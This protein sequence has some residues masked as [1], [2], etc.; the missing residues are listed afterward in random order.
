MKN[1]Q[2]NLARVGMPR[3][4]HLIYLKGDP[5]ASLDIVREPVKKRFLFKDGVPASA[6]SNILNEV[7]GRLL[8]QEGIITQKD[9]EL[10]LQVVL[11]EKKRH[12]QVL[13]S[14][15][16]ITP[17]Q[18]DSFLTLQIK[19]RIFKIFGWNEGTYR[20]V[21][22]DAAPADFPPL[23]LHPAELILE[24]ISLGFYPAPRIRADL[25]EH[26]D[27]P[28]SVAKSFGKYALEDFN[29]NLQEKRFLDSIDGKKTLREALDAS[30][31]LRH[32]ALSLALAFLI[33]GVITSPAEVEEDEFFEEETRAPEAAEATL[34]KKLNAELLFMKSKNALE[35]GEY[36]EAVKTLTG[37]TDLNPMEGEYWAYLGWAVYL[38]DPKN[39]KKAEGILKDAID[40]NNDLDIA[41]HFLGEL[42]QAAGDVEAARKC[43]HTAVEKNPWMLQSVAELKR[44]DICAAVEPGPDA[45][46][47]KAYVEAFGFTDDPFSRAPD[48]KYAYLSGSR[49]EAMESLLRA[50]KKRSGPVL[51][52]GAAGTGKTTLVLELLRRLSSEKILPAVVL[53]P[54]ERELVLIKEINSEVGVTTESDS[55]KEQLLAL[56]MRVSQNKIQGGHT[57][58]VIDQA[59]HLTPGCLKLVQYLTRLKSLQIVLSAEPSLEERLKEADFTELDHKVAAR[60]P[61]YSLSMDETKDYFLKRL[62]AGY[63]LK[64]PACSISDE[65]LVLLFEESGGFP[66]EVNSKAARLLAESTSYGTCDIDNVIALAAFGRKN[67]FEDEAAA[68]V[69]VEKAF[70]EKERAE[71][72][73]SVEPVAPPSEKP[74]PATPA[75][76]GAPPSPGPVKGSEGPKR[77]RPSIEP[78]P[79]AKPRRVPVPAEEEEEAAAEHRTSRLLIVVLLIVIAGLVAACLTGLFRFGGGVVET[80]K[81][82][83]PPPKA[84]DE[85][86]TP[87]TGAPPPPP[88]TLNA[89]GPLDTSAGVEGTAAAPPSEGATAPASAT[90]TG[91]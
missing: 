38:E 7:L 13:I 82:V 61:I 81:A 83:V 19:R 25:K 74:K 39:R 24:G 70:E 66:S 85:V 69:F 64:E 56:G 80:G 8:M 36:A 17:E 23:P 50:V 90:E 73:A 26:M 59:H 33:T 32:R 16:L 40:L 22:S 49:Q 71:P 11:N 20:Y 6:S 87:G 12:G 3:L 88:S 54:P 76:F 55:I 51:L 53:R 46:E 41:W 37:I 62:K 48:P 77:P 31:L 18:L 27:L 78:H 4:L 10:S 65:A 5:A 34:D 79:H 42:Y 57:L 68:E 89:S 43:F 91:P 30:D 28:V 21:K 35:R 75:V 63:G 72:G 9:Y 58:L 2:G 52:T 67:V 84:T 47:R 44:L 45:E 1:R 15:G 14:M 86:T 60:V 29:L